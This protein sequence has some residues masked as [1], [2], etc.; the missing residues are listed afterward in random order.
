MNSRQNKAKFE[1]AKSKGIALKIVTDKDLSK[2]QIWQ[3]QI[4]MLQGDL[5]LTESTITKMQKFQD[6]QKG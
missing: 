4:L 6:H 1:S 3:L 2:I 5:T